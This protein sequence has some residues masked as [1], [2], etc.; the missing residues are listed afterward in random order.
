ML[1]F[2]VSQ[3]SSKNEVLG[4]VVFG[5]VAKQSANPNSDIDLFILVKKKT[6]GIFEYIEATLRNSES[7]F[8]KSLSD[9]SQPIYISPA[10]F[11]LREL[12]SFRPIF[13]DIVDYGMV[14][15]ERPPYLSNFLKK[16]ESLPHRREYSESGEM[17]SWQM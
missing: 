7:T 17:V 2:L 8:F 10:I 1:T 4:I 5:S 13:L 14:L 11:G 12:D 6:P 15:Y 16:Y 9:H 3:L